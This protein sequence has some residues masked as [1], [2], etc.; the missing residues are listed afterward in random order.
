MSG[1]RP[2]A[3]ADPRARVILPATCLGMLMLGINGTAIMA[4]LPT[5]R[6]ELGL[7]AAQLEWAINAYLIVSAVCI[8]PGGKACD[9][10]GAR[11]VS[12]VGLALFAVASVIVAMAH[13][14]AFLLAGRALQGLAA[15]LAVPGTLAAINE[16]SSPERRASAIG[17]WAGFLML[18]FSLGPL[19]G[20]ALT[21]YADW[22]VI[23]WA[24]AV[25]M[26]LAAGGF[27]VSESA[28][29][30]SRARRLNR[31]DWAGFV[32][33]AIFMAALISA[34]NALPAAT[35]A[36]LDLLG[37]AALAVAAFVG[38]L[39][40]E[41]R[42]RDPLIDLSLFAGAAFVRAIA[43]GS[44][45][46]SCILAL[47]LFYNLDAQSPAGL[48]LTPIGAGLS[49]LPLS[50]GL[51]IF[52]FSA[53][54]L[55]RRFGA[56]RALTCGM[57]LIIAGS[58]IIAIATVG[59]IWVPLIVGLFAVGAGLALPYAS[60]PR[61]ALATLPAARAGAGSGIINACTFLAGSVGVAA[62]AVAFAFGG[63]SAVLGLIALLGLVGAWL[64]RE[65]PA[66]T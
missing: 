4:A 29:A 9:Q 12:M 42:V 33:L 21:H 10:A 32:L 14:P 22:R 44:I 17:A 2:A 20:G 43:V 27:L 62:G 16:S 28:A 58:V 1:A 6:G 35:R 52:A 41:R 24:S 7:D 65:L 49:L 45:A 5:M 38:L 34:L 11:R 46:M 57:L 50:G 30:T 19:I 61:L 53:P 31:F 54:W 40:V 36:P 8:I 60:A 25:S 51:L 26:L 47:L 66:S 59:R 39:A 64:C 37:F 48:G 18:G 13:G 23:F 15:A 55:I 56:G 63:L 3:V